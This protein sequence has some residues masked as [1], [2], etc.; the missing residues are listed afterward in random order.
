MKKF[1]SMVILAVVLLMT[2]CANAQETVKVVRYNASTHS[3]E[4]LC[5]AMYYVKDGV[6]YVDKQ[7]SYFGVVFTDAE[8]T[9]TG[10]KSLVLKDAGNGWFSTRLSS[11][12]FGKFKNNTISALVFR[13]CKYNQTPGVTQCYDG[14]AY[15]NVKSIPSWRGSS[16]LNETTKLIINTLK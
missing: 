9:I 13:N 14:Y 11:N 4:T 5:E 10:E 2:V 1:K 7:F 16:V 15:N 8:G 6:L 3:R 12:D